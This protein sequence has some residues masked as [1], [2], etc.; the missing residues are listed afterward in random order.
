MNSEFGGS[1]FTSMNAR[2]AILALVALVAGCS[3]R[4]SDPAQS[5]LTA[6]TTARVESPWQADF[7]M[8]FERSPG[9]RGSG[10]LSLVLWTRVRVEDDSGAPRMAKGLPKLAGGGARI[11]G[12]REFDSR[13][14]R[15]EVLDGDHRGA[16]GTVPRWC[17]RPIPPGQ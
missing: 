13:D 4:E 16:V 3:G 9:I 11:E 1:S 2:K 6:G 17:L 15:I 5:R 8:R 7:D 14:V 10:L 12:D